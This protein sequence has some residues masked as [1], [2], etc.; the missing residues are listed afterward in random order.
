MESDKRHALMN[1]LTDPVEWEQF[2]KKMQ[3]AVVYQ[4]GRKINK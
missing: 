4:R 3:T 1:K 2:L